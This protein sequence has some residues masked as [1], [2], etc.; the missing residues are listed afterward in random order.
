MTDNRVSL[1]P[2]ILVSPDRAEHDT[3]VAFDRIFPDGMKLS[4]ADLARYRQMVGKPLSNGGVKSL[5]NILRRLGFVCIARGTYASPLKRV[6]IPEEILSAIDSFISKKGGC[7]YE[8]IQVEFHKSL[9]AIGIDNR[10][11]LKSALDPDLPESFRPGRDEIS[12]GSEDSSLESYF[13]QERVD[14]GAIS[15]KYPGIKRSFLLNRL[16]SQ[17]GMVRIT[18]DVF[19]KYSALG[20]SKEDENSLRAFVSECINRD[21]YA[22]ISLVEKK[23]SSLQSKCFRDLDHRYI[24]SV[25][26]EILGEGF[27]VGNTLIIRGRKGAKISATQVVLA[28]SRGIGMI[29]QLR[30]KVAEL[31]G[32]RPG[33]VDTLIAMGTRAMLVDSAAGR[34]LEVDREGLKSA[35]RVLVMRLDRGVFNSDENLVLP[36]VSGIVWDRYSIFSLAV[37]MGKNDI[38]RMIIDRSDRGFSYTL[39]S[40]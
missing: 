32:K 36:S 34:I 35:Y 26:S 39:R 16:Y 15:K 10:Y 6:K 20:V 5:S 25:I 19:E 2:G 37:Y 24:D 31:T 28:S 14:L 18:A 12:V 4:D 7:S 38:K 8:E 11:M 9:I 1:L 17:A 29:E 33:L 30:K 21:G 22:Q 27:T 40:A 23:M 13:S 3:W